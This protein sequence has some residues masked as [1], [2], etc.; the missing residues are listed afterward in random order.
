MNLCNLV[1]NALSILLPLLGRA[2]SPMLLFGVEIPGQRV[3]W[4]LR[5]FDSRLCV[6]TWTGLRSRRTRSC[7]ILRRAKIFI[8]RFFMRRNVMESAR[9]QANI[10]GQLERIRCSRATV[11]LLTDPAYRV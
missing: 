1:E 6:R 5:H 2:E 4:V 9:V 11:A 10:I 7:T 3:F 8:D